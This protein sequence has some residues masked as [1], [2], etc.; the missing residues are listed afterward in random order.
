MSSNKDLTDVFVFYT[1]I[2]ISHQESYPEGSEAQF[3]CSSNLTVQKIMWFHESSKETSVKNYNQQS[4]RFKI[5]E[6]TSNLNYTEYMCV[7][8]IQLSGA[9]VSV[10]KSFTFIV[11]EAGNFWIRWVGRN[12]ELIL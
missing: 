7:I 2:L 5:K 11:S 3:D 9:T 1:E 10:N 8:Y 4:L 12:M 6:V